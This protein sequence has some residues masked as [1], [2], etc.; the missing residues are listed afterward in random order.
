M[1]TEQLLLNKWRKLQ[2][3]KQ[4]EVINFIDFLQYRSQLDKFK[5]IEREKSQE[6]PSESLGKK[7]RQ[8]RQEIVDSGLL[9]L[10]PEEV[11]KI[12]RAH[13]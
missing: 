7:L 12:G 6:K 9:L 1:K 11:E 10:N 8:I 5:S 13:V 4:Q 2:P 3:D